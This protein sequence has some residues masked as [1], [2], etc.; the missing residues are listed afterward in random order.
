[1]LVRIAWRSHNESI[2]KSLKKDTRLDIICIKRSLFNARKTC[3]QVVYQSTAN[4]LRL[5]FADYWWEVKLILF[6]KLQ[7][8]F[9]TLCIFPHLEWNSPLV[10]PQ[11][12]F[13]L[14]HCNKMSQYQMEDACSHVTATL[15]VREDQNQNVVQILLP[16]L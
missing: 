5:S 2:S 8:I 16:R 6:E 10:P 3:A 12:H 7:F 4:C 15:R 11:P 14:K 1:M 13:N 9:V